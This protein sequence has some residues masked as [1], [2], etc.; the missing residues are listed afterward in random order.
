MLLQDN[1]TVLQVSCT[2]VFA[3]TVKRNNTSDE[4]QATMQDSI[5]VTLDDLTSFKKLTLEESGVSKCQNNHFNQFT[6]LKYFASHDILLNVTCLIM[7]L[8]FPEM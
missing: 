2:E 8:T 4:N 7:Y 3:G 5:E 1:V 6:K